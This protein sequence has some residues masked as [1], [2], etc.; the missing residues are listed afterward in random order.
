M[1]RKRFSGTSPVDI[2]FF[3]G[4]GIASSYIRLMYLAPIAFVVAYLISLA[5]TIY[6]LSPTTNWKW[7]FRL[8]RSDPVKR[9]FLVRAFWGSVPRLITTALAIIVLSLIRNHP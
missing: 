8:F 1:F 7:R 4:V 3:L 5:E 6:L 2:I 9:E